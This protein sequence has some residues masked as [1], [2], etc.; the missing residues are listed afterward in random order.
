MILYLEFS[1][2]INKKVLRH[3]QS[4]FIYSVLDVSAYCSSYDMGEHALLYTEYQY[5]WPPVFN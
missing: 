4:L 2:S 1:I 3:Q 5:M